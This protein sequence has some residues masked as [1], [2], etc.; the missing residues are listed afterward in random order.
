MK[1]LNSKRCAAS[2]PRRN[3]FGFITLVFPIHTDYEQEQG[4][5]VFVYRRNRLENYRAMS[6]KWGEFVPQRGCWMRVVREVPSAN[7]R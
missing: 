1:G 2:A 6:A 5:L 4:L 7:R 3:F